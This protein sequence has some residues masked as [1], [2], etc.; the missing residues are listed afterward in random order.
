MNWTADPEV[1]FAERLLAFAAVEGIFFSESFGMAWTSVT[2]VAT[3]CCCSRR[4]ES[5]L[6]WPMNV[7]NNYCRLPPFPPE[8]SESRSELDEKKKEHDIYVKQMAAT[9]AIIENILQHGHRRYPLISI[10]N[11]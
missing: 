7:C 10:F 6:Q 5:W 11:N 3:T 1:T 4:R 2:S 8:L 9:K